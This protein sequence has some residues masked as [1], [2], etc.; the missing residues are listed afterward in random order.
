MAQILDQFGRPLNSEVLKSP[1]TARV[2]QITR[3]FP[4]HPSRG[5]SIRRLPRILEA[6]ERGDLSAQA[7]LFEDMIEKDGHIFSEMSKRKN[8]LLGLDW[9]IE[10]PRNATAE[11]KNLTAMIREWMDDIAN[12]EDIILNAAEAI[13]HG[14]SAQEIE[15]EFEENIWLPGRITL[16]PHRWFCTNPEIDDTVRLSDGSMNGAELWPFGWLVHTHNAK[17][18]YVAQSGLY[19]VL[20]WPYLFKNYSVRDFAEFLE[21]YG[22]PAR[23]GKY[24]EGSSAAQKDALLHALVTLGHNAAGIIPQGSEISFEAAADGQSDPFM[25]MI[26]WCERT[27][28]KAVLG[29]TLT[30]QADGKSSTNALGNVHNEV[31]HDILVA[32]A[33]QLHGF[34]QGM[35]HMLLSINGYQVSRRRLPKFVFDTSELEDIGSF[36]TGVS[37]LVQA[38]MK[39]IPLS[40]VHKKVGIPVPQNDEPVLEGAP[41]PAPMAGLSVSPYRAFAALSTMPEEISDS[42][43]VALDSARSTP[44]AINEAMQA[45]IAP[46]VTALQQGQTPDDALDIIAASYPTLDDAQL[47]QLLKQA[48]FVADVWGRLNADS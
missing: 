48:L 24:M 7:D 15:W 33:K 43:Q 29:G 37:T 19:R 20:V 5:L 25:A 6:A 12:F 39:T 9:S 44:E 42:A 31:R 45:L 17:S 27:V 11:E 2:A 32:D 35:I 3:H 23:V 30:S 10:P 36:S 8:A 4:E 28:S 26:D 13:G 46:L 1:Q 34:F 47:Q 14:F 18:G 22:L 40:W 38:G 21:I 16:R 41:T